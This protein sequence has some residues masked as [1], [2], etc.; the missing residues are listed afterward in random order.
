MLS[1]DN[2]RK[3]LTLCFYVHW[4]LP[5]YFHYS[6]YLIQ[7]SNNSVVLVFQASSLLYC[8]L[9]ED[10]VTSDTWS[11]KLIFTLVLVYNLF[12]RWLLSFQKLMITQK[13]LGAVIK[14]IN[15]VIQTDN[16]TTKYFCLLYVLSIRTRL[17]WWIC[18]LYI[19]QF[20][21]CLVWNN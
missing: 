20:L 16:A 9:F 19:H 10:G 3:I 13:P 14:D 2:F 11:V 12:C 21:F 17:W 5:I 1:I 6:F 18:P 15:H 8:N 7:R 4:V